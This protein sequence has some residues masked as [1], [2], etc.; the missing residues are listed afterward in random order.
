MQGEICNYIWGMGIKR[1]F[2]AIGMVV[3]GSAAGQGVRFGLQPVAYTSA[4]GTP[5]VDVYSTLDAS[6]LAY[7]MAADSSWSGSLVV[8]LKMGDKWDA[9]VFDYRSQDSASGAP[10][11]L[12]KSVMAFENWTPVPVEVVLRDEVSGQEWRYEDT[13]TLESEGLYLSPA[14]LLD[15][16]ETELDLYQ[17]SG[18]SVVPMA[19]LG[20]PLYTKADVAWY[21]EVFVDSGQYVLRYQLSDISGQLVP[22]TYGFKRLEVGVNPLKI[23]YNMEGVLSGTYAVALEVL[24]VKGNAVQRK[25]TAFQWFDENM[26]SK[27]EVDGPTLD[28]EMFEARWGN[29]SHIQDYLGM[30]API[31]TLS[32]RRI[33]MNLK[34]QPDTALAAKFIANFW[35]NKAPENPEGTWKG[36]LAI[37]DKVDEEFGSKTMKGYKTQMGRV[38][39]QYGAPS[40][41]EERPFDGKNYPYQIWQYDQLKSPSTPTQQN[42]VF[43][44]VDQELVGR[45][46]TLLH[47]SA[48]GEIKDHKW[49]YHLSRH[50][51][52]GPDID[53]TSTKYGRDNF[54]ERISNSLIIGNQG[55]WFDMY[56]N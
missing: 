16:L 15:T 41:V 40:L 18:T 37:V 47:S 27:W 51:N 49:Q 45:Q 3:A 30:I 25:E 33:L 48:I 50:T 4:Q 8:R 11:L 29:W 53:A 12:Q 13:L 42:Q 39:L 1:L 52:A 55:T 32:D 26:L 44:F 10:L 21:A 28:K 38:F 23:Q 14:L 46:Y 7:E 43:I 56:N 36:Y 35:Q 20:M 54:G 17:K 2:I 22:G 19:N 6:T 5:Y 31:A 24:D 34:D 9:L